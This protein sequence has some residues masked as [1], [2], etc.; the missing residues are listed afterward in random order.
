MAGLAEFD[1]DLT[2]E[3][4]KSDL[5]AARAKDVVLG[6]QVGHRPSDKKAAKVTPRARQVWSIVS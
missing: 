3:R 6:R 1:R 2:R 4:F 5:V